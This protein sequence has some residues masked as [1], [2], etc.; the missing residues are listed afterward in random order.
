MKK[1]IFIVSALFI[2]IGIFAFKNIVINTAF[3]AAKPLNSGGAGGGK[4]GA[5]GEQNCTACH[6]GSTQD[7]SGQNI[8]KVFDG[9]TEVSEYMPGQTY[10]VTLELSSNP[11]KKGFQATVLTGTNFM[12]GQFNSGS[13]TQLNSA[14]NRT[15]AN[16]TISSN[17]SSTNSWNWSWTAPSTG[18]G[19]VTFYVS[20]NE[21]NNNGANSG[22]VIYLSQHVITEQSNAN[23]SSVIFNPSL[24]ITGGLNGN[25]ILNFELNK[26]S[27]VGINVVNI[28]GQSVIHKYYNAMSVG[29]NTIEL[30]LKDKKSGLYIV[31]LFID[32]KSYSIKFLN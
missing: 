1:I 19:D 3:I 32:N 7:G 14:N 12:A 10:N 5:P 30:D 15:Y 27:K 18:S 17:T 16:H 31:H 28:N 22:D 9:T 29:H 23:L 11:S 6:S 2:C 21:A 25:K 8:L 24:N 13:N 26:N 20:S 4:T